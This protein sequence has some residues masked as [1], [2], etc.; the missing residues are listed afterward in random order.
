MG[1]NL[2]NFLNS[3]EKVFPRKLE[4]NLKK[5]III[6]NGVTIALIAYGRTLS[7]KRISDKVNKD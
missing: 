6:E 7:H 5:N 4:R 3:F 2:K 1:W